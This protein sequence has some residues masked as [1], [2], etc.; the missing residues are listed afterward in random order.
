MPA[1][2]ESDYTPVSNVPTIC[3]SLRNSF[4]E[5]TTRPLSKRKA[6]LKQLIAL[7]DENETQLAAAAKA[8][9]NKS[10]YELYQGEILMTKN[11]AIEH[12]ENLDEWAAPEFPSVMLLAK[13]DKCQIRKEPLGMVLVFGAFNYPLQLCLLPLVGAISAGN[14]VIL[15]PS[16]VSGSC[17]KL[18]EELL[19]KYMDPTIL[20]VVNGENPKKAPSRIQTQ[21]EWG[22]RP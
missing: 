6:Q 20:R 1:L 7:L 15:T 12:I 14:T 11:E 9:L 22:R 2:S 17:A 3:A 16:E 18:F 19:H 5:G 10:A 13:P 4:N 21:P 8:D